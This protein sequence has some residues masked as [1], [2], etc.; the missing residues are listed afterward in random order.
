MVRTLDALLNK[1]FLNSMENEATVHKRTLS[2]CLASLKVP[3]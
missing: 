2:G 3:G 1:M